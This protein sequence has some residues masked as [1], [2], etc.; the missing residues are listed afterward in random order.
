MKFSQPIAIVGMG[1]VFP[2]GLDFAN[3]WQTI[4]AAKDMAQ[5]PPAGRWLFSTDEIY[6]KNKGTP[7][8]VYSKKG[9][10]IENFTPNLEGLQLQAIDE[11]DMLF[12]LVLHSGK[13]ALDDA[14][15]QNID[16][17]RV[18]VVLG[19]IVLPT[20]KSSQLA[21]Q[22][23]GREW[24]KHA[25]GKI[26][27]EPVQTSATNRYVAGLPAGL[28]A[29]ALGLG[30]GSY[31]LDAACASSLYALKLAADELLNYRVDAV[32]S[33]GLSRPDCLYTQMGFAQ[34]HALSARGQCAPF[35]EKGDG[36]VVGEGC[37]I[38]VLKRLEDALR[39]Q[40][41]IY[42][43]IVGA[44][45]SN[46]VGGNLLSPDSQGQLQ[47][48]TTA[49]REAGWK[50][51]DVD[52]IEC[53][54]T[55]TP[56]GDTREFESLSTLWQ[57]ETWEKQ[58]CVIGSVKSNI[59]H[60]LTAAGAAGVAKILLSFQHQTLPP[61]ANFSQA[62]KGIDL[63]NSP[64]CVLREKKKWEKRAA[65]TP[66][67]AAINAFGFGGIN[68]HILL[69][70]WDETTK[71]EITTPQ[72]TTQPIAVVGMSAHFG[73]W[74]SLTQFQRRV[75]GGDSETTTTLPKKWWGMEKIHPHHGYFIDELTIPFGRYRIPPKELQ[76]MLPQQLLMLQ[77]ATQAV[78]DANLTERNNAGVFMGIA[79]DLNTT[80]FHFRWQALH[81]AQ[82]WAKAAQ[83]TIANSANEPLSANRT[84]GALGG[85]V[86][87]RIARELNVAKSSF[88]ISSEE[89]SGLSA[90]E[91]AMRSLQNND[92]DAAIVGAVDLAGDIRAV[93]AAEHN[94][95]SPG[96][97]TAFDKRATGSVIGEGAGAIVIKRLEDAIRDNDHIHA[98]IHG[99]G[100]ATTTD[101]HK[102]TNKKA[103]KLAMER[104]YAEAKIDPKTIEY[105]ETHGSGEYHQDAMEIESLI[106]TFDKKSLAVGSVKADIGHTGAACGMASLI[107]TILCLREQIT[108]AMRGFQQIRDEHVQ[109]PLIPKY[110]Q[111]WLHDR[112]QGPRRAGVSCMSTDGNAMHVVLE[113]YTT[114]KATPYPVEIY[115]EKLWCINGN[116]VQE[117]QNK[118]DELRT[119]LNNS[120][121]FD[122][123]SKTWW[124]KSYNQNA[125]LALTM[126]ASSKEEL[127][128]KIL[129][130]QQV[131]VR[132]HGNDK[133]QIF[134]TNSPLHGEVAFV[135]PGSGNHYCGAG[136][137]ISAMWPEVLRAQDRECQFMRSQF[138]PEKFWYQDDF[139]A[140]D[141]QSLIF[142]QVTMGILA[143]DL[144][145]SFS[146]TP[147]AVIGYSLGES[148]GL[149][150]LRAWQN[151]D[152]ML[153]RINEST[154]FTSDLAG[155]CESVKKAWDTTEDIDWVVGIVNCPHKEVCKNLENYSRAYLFIVN[156][157]DECVIGGDRDQV[158]S[159]VTKLGCHFFPLSGITTVHCPVVEPVAAAYKNLHIFDVTP[160]KDIRFYS[161]AWGESYSLAPEKTAQSILEQATQGFNFP[162]LIEKA[163]EDGARIFVEVGPGNSCTRMIHSILHDKPHCAASAC[164]AGT[165][166]VTTVLTLL[167]KLIT[168]RVPLDLKK[169]YDYE[170]TTNDNVRSF[171]V[172]TG[173]EQWPLIPKEAKL[174]MR[175]NTTKH[176]S[177]KIHNNIATSQPRKIQSTSIP[178]PATFSQGDTKI[179]TSHNL[180]LQKNATIPQPH[181]S[182]TAVLEQAFINEQ[183]HI[184]AHEAYLKLSQNMLDDIAQMI[185]QQMQILQSPGVMS[186]NLVPDSNLAPDSNLVPDSKVPDK[187]VVDKECVFPREMCMEYAIGSIAKVFGPQFV[188]ADSYPT[189]VRL[190]DA[191]LMLVDRITLLEGEPCS[192]STGRVVTEHDIQEGA[193]YLDNNRIP[194]C[195]A[196]ES[197]QADLLLSGYLGIDLQT[198]GLAVYRLLDAEVTFHRHL[199]G[200]GETIE[201]DIQILE[202]FRQGNT[203]LFRFQFESTVNG[204]KL[205]TMR[206][207]C[208][209]FFTEEALSSGQGIVHTKL[210][211]QPQVGKQPADWQDLV[212]M[213]V[214]KYSDAQIECLR[215]GDLAGCFGESFAQLALDNPPY[216]PSGKM[217]LMDRV[218]HLDPNG[219][220][221][222]LGIIKSQADIYPDD[223]FLTCHFVDDQV[224]PG[225]LMYE[226]CLHTLRIFLWR[227]GWVANYEELVY[228]PIPGVSSQLK[229]RG[230][231]I[232]ST[233]QAAYQVEIKERGYNPHPYVI[234]DALLF[235]DDKPIVKIS[236]MSLQ[237]TGL[238]RE[239]VENLWSTVSVAT[240]QR[241]LYDY[242]KIYAFSNGLPSE[243]FGE[244]YRI[245]DK[246]R[247]IARLPRPPY[248]FLDRIIDV[249]GAPWE[250]KAGG[251]A[252]AEYDVPV[253]EWYFASN[254]EQGM[255]FAVLLEI[256]LQPCGW[257][258]AYVGS[259]LTSD[260]DLSFRN[261]GGEA[262]QYC[263]APRGKTLTTTV[264]MTSASRSGGMIIQ[265]YS[266]DVRC[267]GQKVYEG[268]TYFGFFSKKALAD[269]VG[270]QDSNW[271]TAP[272]ASEKPTP[273]PQGGHFPIEQMNMVDEINVFLPQGGKHQLGFIQGTKKVNPEEWFFAAHFY[274]DPVCPGSLGLE[275]FLQ[276]LKVFAH[277]RWGMS[278]DDIFETIAVGEKHQWIYRGQIIPQ[279]NLV[280]I[281][282]TITSIDDEKKLLKADGYLGVDGR[283]IYEM[284]NFSLKVKKNLS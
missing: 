39:D 113:E 51:S 243:A 228:E 85:I 169:L 284:K 182:G 112:A 131:I 115:R 14:Q 227:M 91:V 130:A 27:D 161:A 11:L 90:L 1:G 100:S 58:Q 229:C 154:L 60:L 177:P 47:A 160:P 110:T 128:H 269:Q 56:L 118:L 75:L 251:T 202:F 180:S 136:R 194:V 265:H 213:Q 101:T 186:S 212:P 207:G 255:P 15:M 31:T 274:Q 120:N 55:G 105:I 241:V 262:V 140:D 73:K 69:E 149:F 187:I 98:V 57:E 237:L 16:R 261:L 157:H 192:M 122:E 279:D 12:K 230:Q 50:P 17:N 99:I 59:G 199:P 155:S 132:G 62:K 67:R 235:A 43:N 256:A 96:Q 106:E 156:T 71:I 146:L 260:I 68:A 252:T 45:L 195:I 239:R 54:A 172:K 139:S 53:H 121:H 217:R 88:T 238:N 119:F 223:W 165:N 142:G 270:I 248:Q 277:E 267:E 221:F 173:R 8:K 111:Y 46:D 222:G 178:Q 143:S 126:I 117:L 163:Y 124:Q 102:G 145:R 166:E 82:K 273:F 203:Y 151:R 63:E 40:D 52:L 123:L 147:Q 231:V 244:P 171:S 83:D 80:N 141:H 282:A 259:A 209:G 197:G 114:Q 275:S 249:T 81:K 32:L 242:D 198:K 92:I 38:F 125:K 193:W 74:D 185:S 116:S 3:F 61:T 20:E 219:G 268:K 201:Y 167:A 175:N 138:I 210:D 134:Y 232:A 162:K 21:T 196:V 208:A 107:K 72:T 86:A 281:Q 233:K 266:L 280:T 179:H 246:E 5:E 104:A 93:L 220:R 214:E 189:R 41:H 129:E 18:K 19:N 283:I 49:Y 206:K 176:T 137:T 6:D 36:L 258:A 89:T 44:G 204:E 148:I 33:G 37:G 9:C 215:S 164:F 84:M 77:V 188:A 29:K 70:E 234:A 211:L 191:P 23:L 158:L 271:Y 264:K 152:M 30:G 144:L 35:D 247:V 278:E 272:V 181:R 48:L 183:Q 65:H 97:N 159:L 24:Q 64:F 28:L 150:S 225:T 153:K 254:S 103:Y 170:V 76:E 216:L 42:A 257:L 253:D 184:K 7:D 226:C 109:Q 236:N 2:G 127:Q 4:I 66:R 224:M 190:P 168:H 263:D 87:S 174:D 250:M 25:F 218:V 276:L 13:Q 95:A 79:L 240:T 26:V 34:L 135:F 205:L 245:F 94:L 10:F 200:P 108:P 78:E 133:Q 22:I